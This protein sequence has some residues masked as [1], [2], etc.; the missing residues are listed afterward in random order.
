MSAGPVFQKL[1]LNEWVE[2]KDPVERLPVDA[3]GVPLEGPR[4]PGCGE[5]TLVT[6]RGP[7]GFS[8]HCGKC[9]EERTW[10]IPEVI[11]I[12]EARRRFGP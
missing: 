1:Y 8:F 3:R 6:A 9:D 5:R 4:C 11:S 2:G 7:G 10:L 12:A